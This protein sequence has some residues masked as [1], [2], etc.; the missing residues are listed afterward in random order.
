VRNIPMVDLK[1]QYESIRSEINIAIQEVLDSAY[2]I[3]GPQVLKLQK[4][5]EEYLGVRHAI[6]CAN[7][8]DA[9]Q[10][11]LMSLDLKK[12]DEVIVPSFTYVATAEVIALLGLKPVMIDVDYDT[13]NITRELVEKSISPKTKV[14]I[15]VH[16]FGQCTDMDEIIKLSKDHNLAIIEDN[17]QSIGTKY[18]S[19]ELG[20]KKAGSLGTISTTSFYP[21]KNLGCFGDGGAMFTDDTELAAKVKM[22]ANHGQ[23]KKYYHSVIGCNSRLDA[24]QAAVLNVKLKYLE[25][26][27]KKRNDVAD[28]YDRE[29]SSIDQIITP[30]RHDKSTHVFH[31]YTLKVKEDRR[32]DLKDYLAEK[33]ISSMIYYPVP[34]YNQKAF[35][36]YD[37]AMKLVNTELL[38]HEV[39]SLP[40]HTEMNSKDQSYIIDHVKKFF[41]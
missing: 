18:F 24:I 30:K 12:G 34:L 8:T 39:I 14:I 25:S 16:L 32:N 10:I 37:Q 33:G 29:F 21:S 31:Q 40:I 36:G 28:I 20:T 13:F 19:S 6:P 1:T 11:A 35:K 41:A 17:A 7:G 3:G 26:Y 23:D 5:L 2:Y 9:L 15:P 38:C 4:G 22:I 27:H